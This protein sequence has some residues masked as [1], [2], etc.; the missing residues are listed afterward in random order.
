MAPGNAVRFISIERLS[1][2]CGIGTATLRYYTVMG[3]LATADGPERYEE[4]AARER[5]A[6]LRQCAEKGWTTAQIVVHMRENGMIK[7]K[8]IT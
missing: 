3:L 7:A 2:L 5:V 4:K 1:E 6:Y 8:T